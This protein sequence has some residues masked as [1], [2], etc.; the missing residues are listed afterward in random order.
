VLCCLF[1][2]GLIAGATVSSS[3]ATAAAGTAASSAQYLL[4]PGD[5]VAVSVF[6]NEGLSRT[7]RVRGDGT[8]SLHLVGAVPAARLSAAT[9]E[10]A[11]EQL[12]SEKLG[13][14]ASV[15]VE[16]VAYRPVSVFGHVQSPG[17][18]PFSEGMDVMDALALAGGLPAAESG[19]TAV[20]R[21]AEK[22]Q[23][24]REQRARLAGLLTERARLMAERAD[25]T[26]VEP[27]AEVVELVGAE[28]AD[29][30]ADE[31]ARLLAARRK[32]LDIEIQKNDDLR[33][34][35]EVEADSFA[36]RR[37]LSR[38]QLDATLADLA[39]Q[40]KLS[41]RGLALSSRLLE[42][43]VEADGY[44]SN[45]L[46]AAAFEAA[47]RQKHSDAGYSAQSARTERTREIDAR[48]SAVEQEIGETRAALSGLT[49]FLVEFGGEDALLA[50]GPSRIV[51]R[52]SRR[53]ADG[54]QVSEV[55]V[56]AALL[57]GDALEVA[58]EALTPGQPGVGNGD[59]CITCAP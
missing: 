19:T 11:L 47:A 16:V 37:E 53:G 18:L 35:A 58:L 28:R 40:E 36:G 34:L 14:A 3:A 21:V 17:R 27:V 33:Q 39:A 38:R 59:P 46:E 32:L 43:R 10:G 13:S 29:L 1:F 25:G 22:Q 31:Q 42:L 9:L 8:V 5:S 24:Y 48:V 54:P 45:E 26:T 20:M 56:D 30:L 57:P 2:W 7:Y 6:A 12:L 49:D 52:L 51:F 4:S 50:T 55:G 23:E 44:R 41:E 15:T